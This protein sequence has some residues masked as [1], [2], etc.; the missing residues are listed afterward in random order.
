[1]RLKTKKIIAREFLF[2]MGCI[3]V[4]ILTYFGT[5][6]YN[7]LIETRISMLEKS[8]IS[9]NEKINS[10]EKT[11][12]QKVNNQKEFYEK[13]MGHPYNKV[14]TE[15]LWHWSQP[16]YKKRLLVEELLGKTSTGIP[17]YQD[18]WK[19]LE[20]LQKTDSVIYKRNHRLSDNLIERLNETGYNNGHDFNQFIKENSLN[21]DE[22]EN[23][24]MVSN[25]EDN[26]IN[27]QEQIRDTRQKSF[28]D[29]INISS[30][31]L[32]LAILIAFP[33]RYLFLAIRWSIKTLKQKE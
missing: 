18:L 3:S 32:I 4:F 13:F 22:K 14:N 25:M 5:L 29:R 20:E 16:E 10:L 21:A 11:F 24:S 17:K 1:M 6:T 9:I 23:K 33:L 19:S 8:I 26:V 28:I 15:D 2:L 27:L 12:F 30:F 31:L 7:L